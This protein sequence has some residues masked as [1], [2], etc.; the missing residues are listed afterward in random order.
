MKFLIKL[1]AFRIKNLMSFVVLNGKTCSPL[2]NLQNRCKTTIFPLQFE[3]I[4]LTCNLRILF[5]MHNINFRRTFGKKQSRLHLEFLITNPN[6]KL[7]SLN[8]ISSGEI[9]VLQTYIYFNFCLFL[10]IQ[11]VLIE[12]SHNV[13]LEKVP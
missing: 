3:I 4:F 8:Y 1:L 11:I 2:E 13:P 6:N 7:S 12:K 9:V 5:Y 10:S